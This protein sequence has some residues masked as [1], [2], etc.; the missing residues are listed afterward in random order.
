MNESFR[1][2]SVVS[3]E[4]RMYPV[5]TA[6]LEKPIS[7]YVEAAVQ[8]VFDIHMKVSKRLCFDRSL[9]NRLQADIVVFVRVQ[10]PKGDILVFLTGRE[11]IEEA[12][13]EIADRAITYVS[14]RG[15]GWRY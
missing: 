14:P 4:G 9:E 2:R 12:A 6:Y 15:C 5:E 3:L 11:E 7:N 8:T 10:E 1:I 13:Q